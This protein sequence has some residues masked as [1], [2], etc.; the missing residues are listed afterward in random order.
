MV[1]T[2][3]KA[4]IRTIQIF[5]PE[6]TSFPIATTLIIQRNC[7]NNVQIPWLYYVDCCKTLYDLDLVMLLMFHAMTLILWWIQKHYTYW[8]IF[9]LISYVVVVVVAYD[10]PCTTNLT[11]YVF[12]KYIGWRWCPE[13]CKIILIQRWHVV[14]PAKTMCYSFLVFMMFVVIVA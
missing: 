3:C 8:A 9:F 4:W 14:I 12:A 10:G 5:A 7:D 6:P 11:L 2:H 1:L 13:I